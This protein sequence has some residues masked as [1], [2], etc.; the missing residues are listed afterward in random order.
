MCLAVAS[1]VPM[2]QLPSSMEQQFG[3]VILLPPLKCE[4]QF[5]LGLLRGLG[6]AR[7]VLMAGVTIML[8]IRNLRKPVKFLTEARWVLQF[9]VR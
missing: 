7:S 2:L 3:W 9:M 8:F 5:V 4:W 1:L 6:M